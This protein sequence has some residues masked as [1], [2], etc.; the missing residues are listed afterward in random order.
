MKGVPA[1]AL[2]GGK[3]NSQLKKGITSQHSEINR[4]DEAEG[5][6]QSD[7]PHMELKPEEKFSLWYI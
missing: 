7:Y 5:K 2:K 1:T 4:L 3:R 6:I